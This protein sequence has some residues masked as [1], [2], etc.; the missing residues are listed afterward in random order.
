[1]PPC[2]PQSGARC[3]DGSWRKSCNATSRSVPF[4]PGNWIRGSMAMQQVP[5]LANIGKRLQKNYWK[6]PFSMGKSTISMV[7]FNSYVSHYQRVAI[8][9]SYLPFIAPPSRAKFQ[10]I[11]PQV[12]WLWERYST[13]FFL[14]CGSLVK[15]CGFNHR[16]KIPATFWGTPT[17]RL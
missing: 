11:Y 10:Q 7:I 5:G 17:I 13:S 3:A 4:A 12:L 14:E 9:W 1:M 6:S 16:N 2:N 15:I 8:Y